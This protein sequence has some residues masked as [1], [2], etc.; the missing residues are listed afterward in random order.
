[1][2]IIL[3]IDLEEE[4]GGGGGGGGK[5][6]SLPPLVLLLWNYRWWA[7]PAGLV[8]WK[9]T[10]K[11]LSTLLYHCPLKGFLIKSLNLS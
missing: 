6:L 9:S 5:R 11:T 1:M 7:R 3:S 10:S 8:Q 2:K 4:E